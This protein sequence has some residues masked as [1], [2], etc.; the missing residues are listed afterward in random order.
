M[1]YVFHN[2]SILSVTFHDYSMVAL[3]YALLFEARV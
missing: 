1:N 2:M 3:Q